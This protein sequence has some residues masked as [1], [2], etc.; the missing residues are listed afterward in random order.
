MVGVTDEIEKNI[1][2]LFVR[3]RRCYKPAIHA[4][5]HQAL[6]SPARFP[7]R[8]ELSRGHRRTSHTRECLACFLLS[9]SRS[10]FSFSLRITGANTSRDFAEFGW[11]PYR[12]FAQCAHCRWSSP[13]TTFVTFSRLRH[14]PERALIQLSPGMCYQICRT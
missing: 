9:I 5:D 11:T 14:V 6:S 12:R 7:L 13:P 8:G 1:F 3:L 10:L 4:K 2:H